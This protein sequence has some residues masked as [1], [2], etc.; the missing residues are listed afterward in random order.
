MIMAGLASGTWLNRLSRWETAVDEEEIPEQF[1]EHSRAVYYILAMLCKGR[2]LTIIRTVPE[3]NGFES[4]RRLCRRY[5]RQDD[6]TQMGLLQRIL[7]FSCGDSVTSVMDKMA[8]LDDMCHRYQRMTG[9]D[10]TDTIMKAILIKAVPDPIRTHVRVNASVLN[11]YEAMRNAVREYIRA[12]LLPQTQPS[13]SSSSTAMEVDMV[14]K[15]KSGK[16][17]E[18]KGGGKGKKGSGKF[19]GTCRWCQKYGHREADCWDKAAGKPRV[20]G[21]GGGKGKKGKDGKGK[22]RP[23]NIVEHHR[24]EFSSDL[25]V[26]QGG[27]SMVTQEFDEQEQWIFGVGE[28]NGSQDKSYLWLD[29]ACFDHACGPDFMADVPLDVATAMNVKAADG[30]E[31]KSYGRRKVTLQVITTEDLKLPV[32]ATFNVLNVQKPLLSVSRLV[33]QGFKVNF[34]ENGGYL[35]KQGHSVYFHKVGDMFG[36][37]VKV[38]SDFKNE[39]RGHH[40]CPVEEQDDD[41]VPM[42]DEQRGPGDDGQQAGGAA[43]GPVGEAGEAR[44]PKVARTPGEPS[45]AERERHAATHLPFRSWC[46]ACV[47]GRGRCSPRRR[48][49]ADDTK[50]PVVQIDYMYP[51]GNEGLP[52]LSVVDRQSGFGTSLCVRSKG[53]TDPYAV[54]ALAQ[55]ILELGYDDFVL[56]ADQEPALV[57]LAKMALN[58][59]GKKGALRLTPRGSSESNGKV[60]RF[61]QATQGMSRSLVA[62]TE[63]SYD[64]KVGP[65]H[66]LAPWLVRHASFVN[67]RFLVH[68]NGKTSFEDHR[69]GG[70]KSELF[71]FAESVIVKENEKRKAKLESDWLCGLWVGRSSTT[72]EHL[73]LTEKGVTKSRS[74]RRRA[75]SEKFDKSLLG[76]AHGAPW[77]TRADPGQPGDDG[78]G[79]ER[80][81]EV[82]KKVPEGPEKP[83]NKFVRTEGKTVGCPACQGRRN[84]HHNKECVRRQREF[85]AKQADMTSER[86]KD[87]QTE[88]EENKKDEEM[89]G[90]QAKRARED[91]S[92]LNEPQ[93]KATATGVE[94]TTTTG[95]ASSSGLKRSA[96]P[97][98]DDDDEDPATK[99]RVNVVEQPTLHDDEDDVL[100]ELSE[101]YEDDE[102]VALQGPD[103]EAVRREAERHGF[104]WQEVQKAIEEELARLQSFGVYTEVSEK[105]VTIGSQVV[106]TTLVLRRKADGKIK[107][108]I[109]AQD[110]KFLKNRDDLFAPTPTVTGLR[111]L[112]TIAAQKK[113]MVRVGDF[114][115]AFLRAPIDV[116]TFARAPLII[117]NATGERAYW[118]LSRALYGMRK[119]PQLFNKYLHEV[120]E[121]LGMKR[122]KSEPTYYVKDDLH[123]LIH[124]DD[125]IATG[126]EEKINWLFSK[127]EEKM[128][129]KR[130]DTLCVE[131]ELR[132]LG[133]HYTRLRDGGV[134]V[135]HPEKYYEEILELANL[136]ECKAAATPSTAG[137]RPHSQV[138]KE[139]WEEPLTTSMHSLYRTLVGKL[140]V[141]VPERPDLGYE[142]MRLSK[143]L[144]APRYKDMAALKRV[145]RY[146]AGTKLVTLNIKPTT[147]SWK[148]ETWVDTDYAGDRETR[149]SVGCACVFLNGSLLHYHSRQQTVVATSSAEAEYYGIGGGLSETIGVMNLMEELQLE[150][151]ASIKC[152]SSSGRS[153]ALKKGFGRCKHIDVKMAWI[154]ESIDK[155]GIWLKPTK[156][157]ENLADLG[158][159]SL[160]GERTRYLSE[161][162]GL[163]FQIEN[164]VSCVEKQNRS[165]LNRM[166]S[167]PENYVNLISGFFMDVDCS[168]ILVAATTAICTAGG[169]Y[170]RDRYMSGTATMTT[171]SSTS[172]PTVDM[173]DQATQVNLNEGSG[174]Q[175]SLQGK[176]LAQ[177]PSAQTVPTVTTSQSGECWHV[178]PFCRGLS[179]ARSKKRF[180]PC[181]YC[182]RVYG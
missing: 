66:F 116:E 65:D 132:Y 125:P 146:V 111:L 113:W 34:M 51:F 70:Y 11:T 105:D 131:R 25:M 5:D 138:D 141:V 53:G 42:S 67:S 100:E 108:R 79:I 49:P 55:M 119:A 159:K 155:R 107:A 139:Q 68:D 19:D 152:D 98:D 169:M 78:V 173:V 158:T 172:S 52:C 179:G 149:R 127:L 39:A 175:L 171:M 26:N 46:E 126:P 3:G 59:S 27:I 148:I 95:G 35:E 61:H 130:G 75:P 36:L 182:V 143:A 104:D 165:G 16:G 28:F 85:F 21:K 33:K 86:K 153:L 60:E 121:D 167:Q 69:G 83:Y 20:E 101:P 106:G 41:G 73:V 71:I 88:S 140:R 177:F 8:E 110:F 64:I 181:A 1:R 12:T 151:Q 40:V 43:G 162:F 58:K 142:V 176:L 10:I 150:V 23:V 44:A 9:E 144:A 38:K 137:V 103:E 50:K 57:D 24:E 180:R 114:T 7:N 76:K 133:K 97:G 120:L 178:D 74:V 170:L 118:K 62:Q 13:G 84:F 109:C 4:W 32:E 92:E 72:D 156:S 154:Q 48:L 87:A 81:S 14:R 77:T 145:L 129:F 117:K 80:P 82:M 102:M 93:P 166:E 136:K 122:L 30:R 45:L 89:Q 160:T 6:V 17:K 2:A 157:L 54:A 115:A 174:S 147:G 168:S 161:K 164:Y 135:K 18:G 99:R 37:P 123:L 112:L 94:R 31:L 29:S 47:R 124:V 128:S 163:E 56:Q 15:G 96:E 22:G 63:M 134:S 90:R 91:D